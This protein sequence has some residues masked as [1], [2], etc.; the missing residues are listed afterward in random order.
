M[1]LRNVLNQKDNSNRDVMNQ[2]KKIIKSGSP[3]IEIEEEEKEANHL[4]APK[5]IDKVMKSSQS[6]GENSQVFSFE[7]QRLSSN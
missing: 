3:K 6:D 2:N 1:N 7:D 5:Q 4:S